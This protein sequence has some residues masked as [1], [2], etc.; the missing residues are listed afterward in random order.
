MPVKPGSKYDP[1][2]QFLKRQDRGR[3]RLQFSEIEG[4]LQAE[5][6]ASA[7]Q[8]RGFW[9]NRRRGGLQAN[10]WLEAGYR[11]DSV[12]L[13]QG[14]V[15]FRR[16][17]AH[18]QIPEQE[19]DLAWDAEALRALRRHLDLTQAEFAQKMGVRQQTISE[20][21]TGQYQ[22]TR[23]RSKHLKI[24]AERADF[25]YSTEDDA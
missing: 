1:L 10:S 17:K 24:L 23:S 21:E 6:P 20:W 8:R 14:W 16:K 18:Y 22:P 12:S 2:Y 7:R 19:G 25:P 4:L 11:V 13:S 9:S 5:L 3:L 15:E